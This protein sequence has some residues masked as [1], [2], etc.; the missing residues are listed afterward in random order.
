M[1]GEAMF[2]FGPKV[3]GSHAIDGGACQAV[4]VIVVIELCLVIVI[5][6]STTA[7]ASSMFVV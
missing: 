2:I 5:I 3:Q 7:R 4:D 6:V 1:L